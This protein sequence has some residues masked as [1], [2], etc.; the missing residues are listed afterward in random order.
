MESKEN[1]TSVDTQSVIP[2]FEKPRHW[3]SLEELTSDYWTDAETQTK[4]GQEFL[5]K[6]IE[7]LEKIEAMDK[8]GV[9]RRD[10]LTIMGASMA[11]A[12]FACARRPVNKIIP[13]VV[14]PQELTPGV[15]LYYASTVKG[16][17]SSGYGIVVKTREGRPIKIEGNESHP[18]NAGTLNAQAQASV[19]SLYDPERLKAPMKG[20]K[21]GSKSATS[22]SDVDALVSAAL[23]EAKK[24]RIV[25]YP[26]TSETT[27]RL[28]KE[29]MGAFADAK[30]IEADPVGLDEVADAQLDSYGTRVVPH[31]S[32]DQADVV[33]SFG[34]D[35]LGTWG[36]SVEHANLWSKR[37]KLEKA[38][39][40]L[41][42][43][44]VFEGNLSITGA[45]ADE[46]FMTVPGNEVAAALALAHE[47]IVVQK[48]GAYAGNADVASVLNS[49]N[50]SEEWLAKAGSLNKEK[51][52][53]V[54][55]DLWE[56][57]GKSI[58]L[59]QGSPA[60][61]AVINLLNS[62]LGNDGKTI[63][64]TANPVPHMASTHQLGVLLSEMEA[65]Q[66]DVLIIHGL[67]P[68]YFL[69]NG[70]A[71]A[72]A[73]K[74]VKTVVAVNDRIDE[75][76][77][78]A[79]VVLSENHYLEN[80]GDAHVK[81]GVHSLQQ[82]TISPLYDTRGFEEMVINW[83][84]AGVKSS[85]LLSQIAGNPKFSFY[86]YVKENWKT[87][88][89]AHGKGETFN[90]FWELTLQKGV[91]GAMAT[92]SHE[93]PFRVG[94]LKVAKEAAADLKT[95]SI[96]KSKK[97]PAVEGSGLSLQLYR[98]IS[99]GDGKYANNAWL[100]EMPDPITSVT[101]DNCI[102]V[103]VETAKELNLNDNDV[104]TVKGESG[105]FEIPVNVQPGLAKGVVA[106]PVGYGRTAV[107]K[108]G[109]HV[110]ANA[111][112]V[113]K[114]SSDG[115]LQ[116]NG[117]TV[118]VTKT[119]KRYEV[120]KTHGHHRTEGR[121]VLNDIT[122]A[123]YKKNPE[124]EIE[125]EPKLRLK[126]VPSLWTPPV[127]YSTRPYRWMAAVDLNSCIGCSACVIACQAEN[128]IP[129]VGRERVRMSREMHWIRIDRYYSGGEENPQ[130]V[131]QPMMCQHCENA[132]CETVCPVLATT[133]SDDG[134]NQM[135]YSRCVGTRYC[136]NNC[137]YKVRRFNFFD[138]WKDYK[139]S[140]NMIWNPEVT[141]R[142]RGIM[143]KCTF[144][145]QRINEAKGRAK[146]RKSLIKDGELKTA[147]QQTCP[148]NAI[149]FGNANEPDS[150]LN[151]L[152]N[153]PRA[154]R[155]MEILNTKPSVHYL[156]KVRNVEMAETEEGKTG[157]K[158]RA[159]EEAGHGHS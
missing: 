143:E 45:A 113:A 39:D 7:T 54:A 35:F 158:V 59:G 111:F 78:F 121:P 88:H 83:A 105:S 87:L 31:Y 153:H 128:N 8:A 106:I 144:C 61:Q 49:A 71:F 114:F 150:H 117:L 25:S 5:D 81:S 13:Y 23:K 67:N 6:P 154:F 107:G 43:L 124:A 135:T 77:D 82:P 140:L 146:D 12:S 84:R 38:S 103:G 112:K 132:P 120:A 48:K 75:T 42:K 93:R 118:S 125:T 116:M 141:V 147:C 44:Y 96:G 68:V 22:W 10:F 46:R 138:H 134:L 2:A 94:S 55:K 101:W 1:I 29:F 60:L 36:C 64:G 91:L 24:V 26:E 30:W 32:F 34:A 11:M 16:F 155:A 130:V 72:N 85:G 15:A 50:G 53:Q 79:D 145:V 110:G 80:W 18:V 57:R 108:V 76:A 63:D 98:S 136:Q 104:V 40:E 133:H 4:R 127:D 65:G 66:V 119:G 3:V 102:N 62:N 41:S 37:R 152:K 19:L 115:G 156:T 20:S 14:Q 28:M 52:A 109:D 21:G 131:F 74:K 99:M 149:T 89:A 33:V 151:A 27:R 69:P 51:I 129:V 139:D 58:V 148:T 123:Q 159:A 73:M 92:G 86:D 157:E 95:Q 126:V 9:T 70:D 17:G 47:M 100:Q 137:P 97:G 90:D 56:A 142:S 122:L